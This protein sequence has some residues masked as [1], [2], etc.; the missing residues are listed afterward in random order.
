MTDLA[1]YRPESL[2]P[3]VAAALDLRRRRHAADDLDEIFTAD[4]AVT[5]DGREWVGITAVSS[6]LATEA[7]EYSYTSTPLGQAQVSDD[8][9]VVRVHL[10][11][12]F[13]GG[14]VDLDYRFT[15]R[16]GRIRELIISV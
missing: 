7:S 4:A 15:L 13:P 11:G 8:Q 12:D 9:W 3:A 1:E 6:W 14:V 10:A 16:E 5:D 2:P